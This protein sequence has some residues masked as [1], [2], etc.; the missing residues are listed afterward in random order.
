MKFIKLSHGSGGVEMGDILSKLVFS[1]VDEKLKKVEN[2]VGI[3]LPDDGAAIPLKNITNDYIILST[4]AYTVNPP[5]FPGGNI[6]SLAATGSINDVVMTGGK[7]IAALDS[8]V[9]EEGYPLDQLE[10]IVDSMIDVFKKEGVALIGGDFKVMPKGNLD[11]ILITTTVLGLAKKPIVD[12]PKD[13]DV[14]VVSDFVGDHGAVIMLLQMGVADKAS[15]LKSGRLSSDIKPLTRLL[16]LIDRFLDEINAARDPTRGGI[17]GV[18]NEWAKNSGNLIVVED[19]PIRDE[20]R[21]YA[22]MLGIDPMYL[23]SEGAAVFSVSAEV[24]EEFVEDM[25]DLGFENAKIIGKVKK[26]EK[27]KGFVLKKTEIGGFRLLEPPRGEIVPR[28]C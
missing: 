7:P 26:S 21:R 5:F 10:I 16:P 9:V 15:E 18:L 6:G 11:K 27:Y 24:A 22:E 28:I 14:L 20:V 1:K 2:G 19:V 4:D 25:R 12:I 3:D 8:I 13:G 23:A 17:A